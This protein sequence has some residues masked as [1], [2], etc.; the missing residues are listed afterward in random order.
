MPSRRF[1]SVCSL[2]LGLF[3]LALSLGIAVAA[4][5]TAQEALICAG[6]LLLMW[7]TSTFDPTPRS[8]LDVIWQYVTPWV[9][10]LSGVVFLPLAL[11]FGT[12]AGAQVTGMLIGLV[13]GGVMSAALISSVVIMYRLLDS[14]IA[15]T[16]AFR[17]SLKSSGIDET[18]RQ[19][20]AAE[21]KRQQ[22]ER[23][24]EMADAIIALFWSTLQG[25]AIAASV[26]IGTLW[27]GTVGLGIAFG[28]NVALTVA[29]ISWHHKL[30]T[31][32]RRSP[33]LF[34]LLLILAAGTVVGVS[35]FP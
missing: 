16:Q 4:L 27:G 30:R 18:Q 32:I 22:Q 19:L 13:F 26:I 25:I 29:L 28:W 24:H 35:A 21:N 31:R 14:T 17:E 9:V 5:A 23:S 33:R 7:T 10:A 2:A 20:K 3:A 12:L 11:L 8:G 15:R 34:L 1:I 6:L